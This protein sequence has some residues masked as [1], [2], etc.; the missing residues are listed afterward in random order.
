MLAKE[1]YDTYGFDGSNKAIELTRKKL[2]KE[3]LEANLMQGDFLNLTYNDGFFDAVI[4]DA[5]IEGNTVSNIELIFKEV[6]RVLIKSGKYHGM[7]ISSESKSSMGG[8]EI[9]KNTFM[10]TD[11]EFIQRKRVMHF[12]DES[13]IRNILKDVGFSKTEVNYYVD[14]RNDSK[15]F[16]KFWLVDAIK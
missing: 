1:G 15:D 5:A 4:D 14:S 12:F 6:Y 16:V 2:E 8:K 10:E 13:E 11:G 9:E 3:N 7:L